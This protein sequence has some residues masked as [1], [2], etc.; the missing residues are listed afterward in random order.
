MEMH[1]RNSGAPCTWGEW[2]SR[3]ERDRPVTDQKDL[4]DHDKYSGFLNLMARHR[5]VLVEEWHDLIYTVMD[6][7]D[8]VGNRQLGKK[9]KIIKR[10]EVV[11]TR[12]NVT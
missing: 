4:L 2:S 8:F 12:N 6:D 7:F 9:E 3:D 1:K 5:R 11:Q 10:L